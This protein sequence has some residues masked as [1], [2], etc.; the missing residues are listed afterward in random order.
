MRTCR[1][2]VQSTAATQPCPLSD[3]SSTLMAFVC[4]P[5]YGPA[6]NLKTWFWSRHRRRNR[7]MRLVDPPEV[8]VLCQACRWSFSVSPKRLYPLTRA[9]GT[10]VYKTALSLRIIWGASLYKLSFVII[11]LEKLLALRRN[12]AHQDGKRFLCSGDFFICRVRG[13][14]VHSFHVKRVLAN[15]IILFYIF[16]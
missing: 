3:C 4:R 15:A 1:V 7:E 5:N 11:Y 2:R 6:E 13:M 12:V 8:G 9:H 16:S 10:T 14:C